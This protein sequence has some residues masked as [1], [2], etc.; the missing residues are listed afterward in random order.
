[1]TTMTLSQALDV[2]SAARNDMPGRPFDA[3]A[4]AADLV[5][6]CKLPASITAERLA[7]I[8]THNRG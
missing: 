3:A 7:A 4:Y 8:W 5:R 1:M 6:T 2:M